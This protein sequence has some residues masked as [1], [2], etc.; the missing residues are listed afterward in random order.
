MK[1]FIQLTV[2]AAFMAV[3]AA[4]TLPLQSV[5]GLKVGDKAPD[6]KLKNV[7]G[8]A[9]SL[10]DVKDA[11]GNKP[12]GYVLVFTCN[13]CPVA[14]MYEDRIIALHNKLAP[15]GYPVVAIQP[16]DPAVQPADGFEQMKVRARDR[17]YPFLYLFDDGQ[18][19]YP[20]YGAGRTPEVYLLDDQL[21]VQYHGAID[22]NSE[23][24]TAVT[25]RY[26]ESAV[27]ALQKGEKP[28]P[29][30]VKAIGCSIKAKRS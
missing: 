10:Q 25:K 23:D 14:Q 26:V 12:K 28:D 3:L 4:A 13:S 22:N 7:D 8:K 17:Q 2:V 29:A 11:N 19:V 27:A 6:F 21:T 15:Q 18:K 9:Y 20:Q 16:N 24:E 30:E 1:G 5:G